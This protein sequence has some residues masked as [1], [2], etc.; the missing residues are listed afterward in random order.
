[1]YDDNPAPVVP[2]TA[3]T[4]DTTSTT[5]PAVH[6]KLPPEV[7]F[8]QVEGITFQKTKFDH[9]VAPEIATKVRDL[10]LSCLPRTPMTTSSPS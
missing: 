9:I 6:H 2:A 4:T 8:A 10:T 1:M 3:S 7:W 5:T